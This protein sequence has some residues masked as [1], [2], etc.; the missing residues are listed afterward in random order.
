[1]AIGSRAL[2]RSAPLTPAAR[3]LLPPTSGVPAPAIARN[4]LSLRHKVSER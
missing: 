1:M 3:P 4:G 2:A